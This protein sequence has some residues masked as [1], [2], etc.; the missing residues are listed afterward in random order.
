MGLSHISWP[1]SHITNGG[2]KAKF[3][4]SKAHQNFFL[5]LKQHLCSTPVLS[6]LDLKQPFEIEID[7]LNSIV[8][9][10]LTQHGHPMAYHGETLSDAICKYPT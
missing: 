3:V 9:S 1:H 10:I 2:G 6:L 7:A 4:W 8:G 5:D